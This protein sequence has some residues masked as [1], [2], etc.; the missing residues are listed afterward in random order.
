MS[1]QTIIKEELVEVDFRVCCNHSK[2]NSAACLQTMNAIR[3]KFNNII[4][5]MPTKPYG[6]AEDM[7]VIGTARI[8]PSMKD[9]FRKDLK[10]LQ[11]NSFGTRKIKKAKVRLPE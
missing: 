2:N 8:A 4:T 7:C 10:H 6:K 3:Q 11:I 9:K 1:T 5:I